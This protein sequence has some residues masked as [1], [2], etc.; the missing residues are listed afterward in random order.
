M[1][2]QMKSREQKYMFVCIY[3][4]VKERKIQKGCCEVSSRRK[5]TRKQIK[6]KSKR[7]SAMMKNILNNKNKNP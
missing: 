3:V 5:K 1:K 2:I 4:T 6:K 7:F